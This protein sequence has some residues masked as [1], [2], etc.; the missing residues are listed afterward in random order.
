M[1][2]KIKYCKDSSLLRLIDRVNTIP[3]QT[4]ASF[5]FFFSQ[6]WER[7]RQGIV[8]CKRYMKMHVAKK[9]KKS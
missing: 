4:A 6:A 1:D 3:I 9:S 2:Q 7:L 8:D 5:F